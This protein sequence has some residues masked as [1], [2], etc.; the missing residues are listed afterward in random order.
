MA[1][2]ITMNNV[3]SYK[4]PAILESDKKVTLIY[5]HNG[6]GKSTLSNYLY[7]PN[8][9]KFRAC[10]NDGFADTHVYVYNSKFV[11][12]NFYEIDKLSG[13]LLYPKQIKKLS[14][15]SKRRIRF[16]MTLILNK[17][18]LMRPYQKKTWHY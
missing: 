11:R 4:N 6:T 14:S 18:H 15:K 8:D 10:S 5:G 1:F 13:I 3:A 2:K 9:I 7:E 12:E 16:S 17:R